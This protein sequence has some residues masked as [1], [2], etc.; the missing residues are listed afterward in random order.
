MQPLG[1]EP[2]AARGQDSLGETPGVFAT[3]IRVEKGTCIRPPKHQLGCAGSSAPPAHRG[4][5]LP[6]TGVAQE[7]LPASNTGAARSSPGRGW[8]GEGLGRFS[9]FWMAD[10]ATYHFAAAAIA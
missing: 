7:L 8:D 1:M 9:S 5:L 3:S 6:G 2:G 4:E 10:P